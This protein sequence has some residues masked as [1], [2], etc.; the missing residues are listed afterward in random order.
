M[1]KVLDQMS[2]WENF[3]DVLNQLDEIFKLQDDV[4]KA[5]EQEKKKRTNDLFDD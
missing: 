1:Q 5:T 3:I 4:L 2:L